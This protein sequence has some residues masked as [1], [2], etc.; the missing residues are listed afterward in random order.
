VET[1][2][3]SVI[4]A[5]HLTKVFSGNHSDSATVAVNDLHLEVLR[6][7]VFGFLGPNGSGKTTTIRMLLGLIRPTAGSITMFGLD[8]ARHLQKILPRI[9]ALVETPVFYP[10]LSGLDNLRVVAAASGMTPGKV[11]QARIDE[12]LLLVDLE[13]RSRD[14]Y[15]HYSLGMKQ[16][17]A[18]AAVLLSDPELILLDEPTNGLD[19]A[20]VREIRQ[21]IER[22]AASGKTIF[23]SSHILY[24]IQQVCNVVAI[25]QK[26]KLIKQGNVRELLGGKQQIV[27]R[28]STSEE[29]QQARTILQE[30]RRGSLDWISQVTID[31][32]AHQLP[33][34]IVDAPTSRS[35]EI[36][37][38]LAR[39]ELFVAEIYQ[40]Q[41][42]LEDFFLELTGTDAGEGSRAHKTSDRK[43]E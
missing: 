24:E 23:L 19:P 38:L 39:H 8:N 12:V 22:L 4:T 14:L 20:G 1:N 37:A 43:G 6:G 10:Y 17:L 40:R 7:D 3:S 33:S 13:G 2:H 21:L 36:T 26:G 11:N 30:A 41:T 42:N 18:I 31:N 34:L 35:P 5:S 28:L 29:T 32:D 15:R 25:L 27:V 16:R 9:G